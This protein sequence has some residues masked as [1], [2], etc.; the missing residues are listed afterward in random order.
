VRSGRANSGLQDCYAVLWSKIT[1]KYIQNIDYSIVKK[2]LT[3]FRQN[4]RRKKHTLGRAWRTPSTCYGRLLKTEALSQ[5]SVRGQSNDTD[6]G[7]D[8]AQNTVF[9]LKSFRIIFPEPRCHGYTYLR[10][11][12]ERINIFFSSSRWMRDTF[13][14]TSALSNSPG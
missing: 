8:C 10:R 5:I 6:V 14:L 2:Q 13:V 9:D 4:R 1:Q 12:R 7:S 11:K 3:N